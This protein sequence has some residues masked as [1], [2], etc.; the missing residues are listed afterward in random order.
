[1]SKVLALLV[2]LVA[3]PAL[4]QGV[5]VLDH[6]V[7]TPVTRPDLPLREVSGLAHD[8]AAGTLLAISDRNDLFVLAFD[9]AGDRIGLTLTG[10]HR[11]TGPDDARLR[12]SAFSAE[13]VARDPVSGDLWIVS[14]SPPALAA[15]DARGQWRAAGALPGNLVDAANLR[16]PRNGL[17]SLALHPDLGLLTA[18]E[19]PLAGTPRRNHVLRG[20]D[21][22]AV[23]WDTGPGP[24]TNLKALETLP[25]G[26]LLA[27]ER[28]DGATAD[29]VPL[30]RRID[31]ALCRPDVPCVAPEIP[32]ALPTPL[33][34]DFEALV[35]LGEGR[36]LMASDDRVNGVQRTVFVLLHL[37]PVHDGRQK[38]T[39]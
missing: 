12:R 17:E 4:G 1:M 22:P 21:G 36:L 39:D 34:A 37:D 18:P 9:G 26:T 14:E 28:R 7:V 3:T 5:V 32:L 11:L 15:F 2:V 31:P 16:S 30:L 38:A 13:G 19:T 8:P 23:A 24:A 20:P 33:D 35:W 27:L 6:L 25:D 29:F 10:Q